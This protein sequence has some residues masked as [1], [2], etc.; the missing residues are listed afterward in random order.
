MLMSW[1]L[2]NEDLEVDGTFLHKNAAVL[3]GEK[4]PQS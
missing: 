1:L 4:S 2:S 3:F